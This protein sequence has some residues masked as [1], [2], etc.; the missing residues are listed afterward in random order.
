[1]KRDLGGTERTYWIANQWSPN[2][3][4]AI[5]E[6]DGLLERS[7]LTAALAQLQRAHRYLGLRVLPDPQ[8][9]DPRFVP[10][11][12]AIPLAL[13]DACAS[14]LASRLDGLIADELNHFIDARESLVRVVYAHDAARSVLIVSCLHIIADATSV[15]IALRDLLAAYAGAAPSAKGARLP[16]Y[17]ALLPAEHRGWRNLP[18]TLRAQGAVLLETLRLRPRRLP[19]QASVPMHLRQNGYLRRTLSQAELER[20]QRSCAAHSVTLHGLLTAALGLAVARELGLRSEPHAMLNVGS[21]VSVRSAL[22]PAVAQEL[23]SYVCTL[24][25]YMEVG[26]SRSLWSVARRVNEEL[27]RRRARAEPFAVLDVVAWI[28]PRSRQASGWLVDA[29]DKQGPGNLCLSNIGSFEMP[30]ETAGV[31]VRSAHWCASLSITGYFLCAVCATG[32]G[33]QL[34]FAYIEHIVTS[35]RA[36]RI[37]DHMFREL[38]AEL[39]GMERGPRPSAAVRSTNN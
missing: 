17:E 3:V 11:T 33:L 1:M 9:R 12:G 30:A 32:R 34:D 29:A 27:Q 6:L 5:A 18:R 38:A 36:R 20:L 14:G 2:N 35:D 25:V 21:P 10:R 19:A 13:L 16:A 39:R 31:V 8:G 26:A 28:A 24:N 4:L 15:M 22:G 23:G 37:V 7:Q